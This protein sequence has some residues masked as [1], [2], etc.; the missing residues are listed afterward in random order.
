MKWTL[1]KNDEMNTEEKWCNEH[2]Q[3]VMPWTLRKTNG[4]NIV[5]SDGMNIRIKWWN[6]QC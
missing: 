4:I 1:S 6:E 5:K 2:Y 3:K